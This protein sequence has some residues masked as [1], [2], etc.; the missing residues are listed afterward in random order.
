MSMDKLEI[1][2][3]RIENRYV[4]GEMWWNKKLPDLAPTNPIIPYFL[5]QE[6]GGGKPLLG[7]LLK[8]C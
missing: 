7:N 5:F 6:T 8:L 4:G 2:K 3:K 1:V